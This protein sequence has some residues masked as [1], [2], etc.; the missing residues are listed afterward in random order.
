M[1]LTRFNAHPH[2]ADC[3]APR[4]PPESALVASRG[5]LGTSL[6]DRDFPC[7]VRCDEI[8]ISV[9]PRSPLLCTFKMTS[10]TSTFTQTPRTTR[11]PRKVRS[12]ITRTIFFC[13]MKSLVPKV[14]CEMQC[15]DMLHPYEL[16]SGLINPWPKTSA[17]I[18]SFETL[19]KI[20]PTTWEH[21]RTQT[22][23]LQSISVKVLC[24]QLQIQ[25]LD[26][27]L[28]ASLSQLGSP[29]RHSPDSID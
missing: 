9:S 21:L 20:V 6:S 10:P 2:L 3:R 22:P 14:R 13:Q 24:K 17:I 8:V 7:I 25:D 1:Q 28:T 18:L 11:T 15:I 19:G 27:D 29:C 16:P 26:D 23:I 12:E 5:N 4:R